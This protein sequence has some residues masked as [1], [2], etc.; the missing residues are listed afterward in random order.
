MCMTAQLPAADTDPAKD[1]GLIPDTNLAKLNPCLENRC[2]ILNQ[3]SEIN[4]SIC[5]KIKKYLIRGTFFIL[6][7]FCGITTV[8]AQNDYYLKQAQSYQREAEYYTKQAQGYEREVDYY[9]RKA[10]G[11]L[12]EA[13]YYSK[14]QKY[15][16]VRSYQQYAKN[17]T[18]SAESY[19]RKAKSAR[20][21]AQSY[22]KKAEDALR[23][24]K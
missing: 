21:N 17:A 15:D 1:L 12:R 14:R 9:N 23:K 7:L 2:Q 22:M 5:C 4:S 18:D 11:Y 3:L 24:A 10:Q 6:I 13:E 19:Q 20:E 16:M 8:F